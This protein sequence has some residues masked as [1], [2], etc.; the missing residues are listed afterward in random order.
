VTKKCKAK[1]ITKKK[2]SQMVEEI[3]EWL[4]TDADA[5]E[6]Q[7]IYTMICGE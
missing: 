6:I 7:Q 4:S 3:I 2:L 1:K 5:I